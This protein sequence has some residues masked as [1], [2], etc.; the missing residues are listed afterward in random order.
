VDLVGSGKGPVAGFCKCG[1]KPSDSGTTEL[2]STSSRKTL[3]SIPYPIELKKIKLY[4][5]LN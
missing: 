2:D 5:V 4:S 3:V 1:D